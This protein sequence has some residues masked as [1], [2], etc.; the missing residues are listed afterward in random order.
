MC[1]NQ[2]MANQNEMCLNQMMAVICEKFVQ[3]KYW[4]RNRHQIKWSLYRVLI[5][6]NF[7]PDF[8]K[9]EECPSTRWS[10]RGRG[11]CLFM[12][13][14]ITATDLALSI[15]LNR[16]CVLVIKYV[17][18]TYPKVWWGELEKHQTKLESIMYFL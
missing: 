9:V 17:R 8:F 2:V 15:T 7:F 14:G 16:G 10:S 4:A 3:Q 6:L 11:G 5:K 12:K 1:L 18:V 13:G